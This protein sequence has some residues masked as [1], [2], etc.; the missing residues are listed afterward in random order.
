MTACSLLAPPARHPSGDGSGRAIPRGLPSDSARFVEP[1]PQQLRQR[2]ARLI[3]E[4][5]FFLPPPQQFPA[6]LL[7]QL[8]ARIGARIETKP[9][10]EIGRLVLA[11]AIPFL[12]I[13]RQRE[14]K[15]DLA[16]QSS[17]ATVEAPRL[18]VRGRFRSAPDPYFA[19]STP[20][21]GCRS[22][23]RDFQNLVGV[24]FV[25]Q[26]NG[27]TFGQK[28]R[29]LDVTDSRAACIPPAS[30][31]RLPRF[32]PPRAACW[33]SP[34][35]TN[36]SRRRNRASFCGSSGKRTPRGAPSSQSTTPRV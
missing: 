18:A 21:P 19:R 4:R 7:D 27:R 30:C 17:H 14:G 9:L 15:V 20:W 31:F 29:Q 28:R 36:S 16:L 35:Q 10:V 13:V 23:D 3:F 22:L 25:G 33:R 11:P 8:V 2:I 34:C 1:R 12:R 6:M 32:A 26:L 24:V 5:K